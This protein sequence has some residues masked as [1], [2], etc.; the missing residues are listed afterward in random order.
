MRMAYGF[1]GG[2]FLLEN[3]GRLPRKTVE[4]QKQG[5]LALQPRR[6]PFASGHCNM[7]DRNVVVTGGLLSPFGCGSEAV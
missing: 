7:S 2:L 4:N 6:S 1:R 3:Q 5:R